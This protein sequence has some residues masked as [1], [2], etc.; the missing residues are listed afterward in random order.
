VVTLADDDIDGSALSVHLEIRRAGAVVFAGDTNTANM[1]RRLEDLA[2]YLGRHNEFPYGA[3]LLTGTGI[4]PG[5]DFTL[6][7]GDVVAVQIEAIGTLTNT[8]R[9]L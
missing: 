9:L 5:D 6:R 3:V 8:V 1:N 7:D 4:V 2:A